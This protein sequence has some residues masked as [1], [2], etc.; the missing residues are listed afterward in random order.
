LGGRFSAVV[1]F[2]PPLIVTAAQVD[3]ISTIFAAA[4]RA[5]HA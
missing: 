2:L 5:V 1:R 3:E 4:V